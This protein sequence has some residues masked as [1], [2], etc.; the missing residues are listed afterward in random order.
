MDAASFNER[1]ENRSTLEK[2]TSKYFETLSGLAERAIWGPG[3]TE[4]RGQ[5][6]E[7]KVRIKQGGKLSEEAEAAA[8]NFLSRWTREFGGVSSLLQ[9]SCW[10]F[11]ILACGDFATLAHLRSLEVC[12]LCRA[13]A[14]AVTASK[15]EALDTSVFRG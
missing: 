14:L 8:I 7:A 1:T 12:P 9:E 10:D 15:F 4:Q 13:R 6:G 2:D 5:L 11:E 3:T